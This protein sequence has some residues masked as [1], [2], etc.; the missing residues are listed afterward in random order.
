MPLHR[1]ILNMK[2][3]ANHAIT[4]GNFM[5]GCVWVEDKNGQTTALLQTKSGQKLLWGTR[6]DMHDKTFS[7]NAWKYHVL[8]EPWKHVGSCRIYALSIQTGS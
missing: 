2:G 3:H 4:L 8:E 5:E 7:F 1:D 6:I